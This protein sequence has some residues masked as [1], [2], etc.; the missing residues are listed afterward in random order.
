MIL[1]QL[2]LNGF[3]S[4][5]DSTRMDFTNGFTAVVGPNGCGKSNISDAIRWVIGEQSAKTLR[6]AKITDLIFN[7][8]SDRKPVNRAEISL[9]L[10]DVPP[11]LRIANVPN[12]SDEIKITRCCHRSGESE[13]LIN[14]IPCRL[15]D[16]SDLLLDVGVSPKVLTVIEQG[17]IQDIVTS[18][19]EER[20]VWIEEAAGILKFKTRR[21]EA[22]RKLQASGQNLDRISDI[23]QEL[24][25]QSAS[26]KRQSAKAEKYKELHVRIKEISLN[27]S[28]KKIRRYQK[29]LGEI[30]VGLTGFN[31]QKTQWSAKSS[32]LENLIVEQKTQLDSLFS[33]Q[34]EKRE[35][36]H[37]ISSSIKQKEHDIEL[38][39]SH[40]KQAHADIET[41][42]KET[43][44][45]NQEIALNE[46]D[47]ES[48]R[49]NLGEVSDEIN[50][51]ESVLSTKAGALD[52]LKSSLEE[53]ERNAKNSE[54]QIL[55]A[56]QKSSRLKSDKS[57]L[58]ARDQYL[59]ASNDKLG[60]EHEEI[61][62]H[63]EIAMTALSDS[64]LSCNEEKR[65]F[66]SLQNEQE[67]IAQEISAAS[68][69]NKMHETNLQTIKEAWLTQ[70]STLNSIRD[71]RK[72]FEGF[73]EGVKSLMGENSTVTGL[74]KA[75]ADVLQAP[76]EYEKAI[77]SV[78]GERLQSLI[79]E[80]HADSIAAI[81]YLNQGQTGRGSFVPLRAKEVRRAP[82][83]L[84]GNPKII[85]KAVDLVRATEEYR[86]ILDRI[87]GDTV[88]T[89]DL[90]T[91]IS[92]YENEEFSGTIVTLNGE[93]IDGQ[94]LVTGGT[95]NALGL[96][97]QNRRI[98]DLVQEVNSLQQKLKIA[99]ADSQKLKENLSLLEGRRSE[100]QTAVHESEIRFNNSEKDL[101]RLKSETTRLQERLTSINKQITDE[102]SEQ[103]ALA[104][105]KINLQ[106]ELSNTEANQV[107]AEQA[108]AAQREEMLGQ[109][110]S[111]DQ[112]LEGLN[113]EKVLSASLKGKRENILSNVQRLNQQ[114]DNLRRSIRDREAGRQASYD[115]ISECEEKIKV[116]EKEILETAGEEDVLKEELVKV[117]ES[118]NETETSLDKMEKESKELYRQ[119]QEITEQMS[120][121][122][123]R[124]SE[125]KINVAHIEERAFEDYNVTAEE[126]LNSYAGDVNEDKAGRD[127]STLKE[128]ISRLGEV[129]LAALSEY[130][131]VS[132]RYEFLARQQDDLAA[133]VTALHETIEKINT[134]THKLFMDTFD[135]VNEHF[136]ALFA[137]LFGGG[138]AEMILCDPD[139]PLESG[140]DITASPV[141]KKMLHLSLLSG[142]EKT[143]TAIA[144]IF[145]ILKVRPSPF[146]LL[147]EVDAPLDEA[148]VLRL[149][150]ILKEMSDKTQFIMITHNQKTMSFANTLYGVTME[151]RGVSKIVSV[152]LNQS[153]TSPRA[154]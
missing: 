50:A 44:R 40:L 88:I 58:Q 105:Q 16:I 107:Q 100:I 94:G 64:E 13:F 24:E 36:L 22:L 32:T 45:M 63:L 87:L 153:E 135:Q 128:K 41:A 123:L 51:V 108:L 8:S 75:L 99:T 66:E 48:S 39:N 18:K 129:N 81:N 73:G 80:T 113:V 70:S 150:E 144:M 147:D 152:N 11:G 33:S 115:K 52:L 140:V 120:R 76:A 67:Q 126:I 55:E 142:G 104:E 14:Q 62:G 65:S 42:V 59:S 46:K 89:E 5:V 141:G 71:L 125:L 124:Q 95:D 119:V 146:C 26:L 9:T 131:V 122:E 1:K 68:N 57:A 78:L 97:T 3:K 10:G 116:L 90:E 111:I 38:T 56:V 53:Q 30:T 134:T 19:P 121:T 117:E 102:S 72:K 91:A 17:H 109:R 93:V 4:F 83:Y 101:E 151:E 77:E 29:E 21:N 61:S 15:K 84:N 34:N 25:R 60:R 114:L 110:L 69:E 79:V 85:G 132:E 118:L 20:R 127:L 49:S 149:Q 43:E 12:I 103:S 143:M 130:K 106:Q 133:S 92:L 6:G 82:L 136:K 23:V 138:R 139:N 137:R 154:A 27:L 31:D 28:S 74:R 98:E 86:S 2:D 37:G 7:G 35:S 112:A 54:G 148:N 145:A 96:L 47:L